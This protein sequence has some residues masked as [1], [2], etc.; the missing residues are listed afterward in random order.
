[1]VPQ[2]NRSSFALVTVLVSALSWAT[3]A[4]APSAQADGSQNED[5]SA[6]ASATDFSGI[7]WIVQQEIAAGRI[8][9]AVVVIGDKSGPLY[10]RAFG[11]RAVT[12]T[13][14]SMTEDTVFDLASLTKVVATTTAVL[15]LVEQGRLQLDETVG[16]YWLAFAA[17]GKGRI[18]VRQLLTHTS[19]LSA[20]LSLDRRWDGRSAALRL[21]AAQSLRWAPG[22]HYLYS[23]INFIVLGELVREDAAAHGARVADVAHERARVD[24]AD[25]LHA[26]VAQP[27]QPAALGAG[28]VLAVA[29]L[30]HDRRA[31]PRPLGLHRL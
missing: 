4:A 1:M 11:D 31:R 7:E 27:V 19:G 28:R 24:A 25:R 8:P 13:R 15:Q 17:Q 12:P 21:V 3:P 18:T 23:D 16:H 6:G 26:A 5:A 9:G 30:A 22:T 14:E 10:R 29:R 2:F 20:D